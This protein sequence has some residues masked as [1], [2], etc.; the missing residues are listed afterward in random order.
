MPRQKGTDPSTQVIDAVL[1]LLTAHGYDEV[2][3][4]E[5][6]RRAHVSLA[7]VYKLFPTRDELIVTA[8]EQ[9]MASNTY[10]DL[11]PPPPGGTLRESLMGLCRTVFEPWERHPR[12]LEAYHRARSGPGGHRLDTQGV[13]AV[14]PIARDV[15]AGADPVYL[16]DVALILTNVTYTLIGR[17]AEG[18]LAITEILP[19]IERVIFRLTT[20][21][22]PD[23]RAAGRASGGGEGGLDPSLAAPF[24]H[25]DTAPDP[26]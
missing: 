9:W 3:L 6:A 18:T 19:A 23:A 13:T 17:F 1:E 4:R 15:L 7:T 12:M 21:N 14:F 5:V 24:Y 20:D 10:A 11:T 25:P 16:A 8:V 22:E 2:Q 26:G